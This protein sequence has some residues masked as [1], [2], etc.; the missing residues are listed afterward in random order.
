[1]RHMPTN[2]LESLGSFLPKLRDEI[3]DVGTA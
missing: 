1:M 3:N 2:R